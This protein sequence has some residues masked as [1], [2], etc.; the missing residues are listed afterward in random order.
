MFDARSNIQLSE[1]NH[2]SSTSWTNAT[3]HKTPPLSLCLKLHVMLSSP[4]LLML[5]WIGFDPACLMNRGPFAQPA[6][7]RVKPEAVHPQGL[8]ETWLHPAK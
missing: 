3:L 1:V 2:G 6:P 7:G 8:W 4:A 5:V